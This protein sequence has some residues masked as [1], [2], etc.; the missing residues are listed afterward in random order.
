[1]F[2]LPT[3][4]EVALEIYVSLFGNPKGVRGGLL[5]GYPP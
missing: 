4:L 5:S 3:A 2:A 1:L